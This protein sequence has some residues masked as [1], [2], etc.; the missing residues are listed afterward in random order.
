MTL[1]AIFG[2]RSLTV[3]FKSSFKVYGTIT[4]SLYSSSEILIGNSSSL[5]A[6]QYEFLPPVFAVSNFSWNP[7][8]GS[9]MESNSG[10]NPCGSF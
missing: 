5:S 8:S 6:V 2:P 7:F 3:L 10:V 9:I 1:S 4:P